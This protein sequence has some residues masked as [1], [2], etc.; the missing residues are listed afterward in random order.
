MGQAMVAGILD[1]PE[2]RCA[3]QTHLNKV[4]KVPGLQR[5][6]LPVIGKAEQLLGLVFERLVAAQ[7]AQRR[8]AQHRRRRTAPL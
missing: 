5:R 8:Q 1:R 2:K 4:V 3:Q 7:G 6:I